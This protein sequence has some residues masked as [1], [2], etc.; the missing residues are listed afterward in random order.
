MWTGNWQP[1]INF[2]VKAIRP[3]G[4]I[5][6]PS[7]PG[8]LEEFQV[9]YKQCFTAAFS[10]F[11]GQSTNRRGYVYAARACF[12]FH[13]DW[14]NDSWQRAMQIKSTSWKN[15]LF[16]SQMAKG[17]LDDKKICYWVPSN[18]FLDVYLTHQLQI[19]S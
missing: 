14:G 3:A 5:S 1:P 17:M 9:R 8:F 7:L 16:L 10:L 6:H 12:P 2:L 13:C 11:L 4:M 15:G 18:L 19:S